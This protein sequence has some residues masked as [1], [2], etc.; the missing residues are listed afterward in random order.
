MIGLKRNEEGLEITLGSSTETLDHAQLDALILD[1]ARH[2]ATMNPE[3]SYEAPIGES[4]TTTFDP[5]FYVE[6]MPHQNAVLLMF[7][8]FGFGWLPFLV[9]LTEAG[10]LL[11]ILN[12]AMDEVEAQI[13]AFRASRQ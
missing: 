1:L 5:R 3:H 9:P 8:H 11:Q 6:S 10:N 2:R 13:E 4:L 12:G 7:R